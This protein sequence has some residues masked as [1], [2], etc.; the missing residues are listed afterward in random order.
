VSSLPA[1]SPHRFYCRPYLEQNTFFFKRDPLSPQQK[2][3]VR[4]AFVFV[5]YVLTSSR[6]HWLEFHV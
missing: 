4:A 5:A 3:S 2:C 1:A 6:R